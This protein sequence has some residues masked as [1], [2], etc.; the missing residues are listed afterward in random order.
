MRTWKKVAIG[1]G[2]VTVVLVGTAGVAWARARP[3][4]LSAF[5]PSEDDAIAAA[6]DQL[7]P[8]APVA[9]LAASA[10]FMAYPEGPTPPTSGYLVA[11]NRIVLKL[12]TQLGRPDEGPLEI[13]EAEDVDDTASPGC[14]TERRPGDQGRSAQPESR[15]RARGE[16]EQVWRAKNV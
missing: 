14:R 8:D 11:W 13:P 4:K 5:I 15:Y 7:G 16:R 6:L 10:Y 1:V 9:E 3:R 12:R 2:V